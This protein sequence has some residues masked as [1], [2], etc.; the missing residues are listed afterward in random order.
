MGW[1]LPAWGAG[2][3]FEPG[4]LEAGSFV[5]PVGDSLM[6][7]ITYTGVKPDYGVGLVVGVCL[8]AAV[9]PWRRHNVRWAAC[10][11]AR[12]HGRNITCHLTLGVGGVF[13]LV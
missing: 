1:V 2:P 4:Q 8:G 5:V 6:Q 13:A 12:S 3:A 10:D 11:D 9:V 7:L